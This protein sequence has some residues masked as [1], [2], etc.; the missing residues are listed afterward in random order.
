MDIEFTM[1]AQN[2]V[3]YYQ[4]DKIKGTA[5]HA[6][7]VLNAVFLTSRREERFALAREVGEWCNANCTSYYHVGNEN[8]V[9]V[10][11]LSKKD[12]R[13]FITRFALYAKPKA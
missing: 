9:E 6:L 13:A 4:W 7:M 11:F 1:V 2:L 10:Y 8:N 5:P 3:S 12:R